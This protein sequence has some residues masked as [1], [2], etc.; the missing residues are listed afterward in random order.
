MSN[1]IQE[2]HEQKVCD[3]LDQQVTEM[4][5]SVE[6]R[7][8]SIRLQAIALNAQAKP[9]LFMDAVK[10]VSAFSVVILVSAL[11]FIQDMTDE[12]VIAMPI[13]IGVSEP[14]HT[15]DTMVLSEDIAMLADM[16]F[17]QWL[18]NNEFEL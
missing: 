8:A 1:K 15:L 3:I 9:T 5:S 17:V 2:K 6:E 11:I 14:T 12:T 18:A 10:Y 13:S 7:L 4:D 16:E